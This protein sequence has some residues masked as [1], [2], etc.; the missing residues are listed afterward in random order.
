MYWMHIGAIIFE[1]FPFRYKTSNPEAS[2]KRLETVTQLR[3]D[4]GVL[5]IYFKLIN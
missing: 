1:Q 4:E 5:L 2:D 3:V